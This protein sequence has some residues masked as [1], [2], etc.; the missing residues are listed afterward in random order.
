MPLTMGGYAQYNVAN[1]AGAALAANAL[2]ISAT[3]I[4]AVFGRFGAEVDD[5][6]GRMMR[7][8][9]GGVRILLDYAHNPDGLRGFL[10]VAER[11]RGASGRFG[12]L[13]GHAGNRQ[14]ADIE[15]LA[16]VAA[17]S[18]PDLVVVK[19]IP[20]HLRGRAPGEIPRIIHDALLSAGVPGSAVVMRD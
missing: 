15:A 6:P 13:L 9:I 14:D 4:A 12:M 11:L 2:G 20:T 8:D 16:R 10:A 17:Q 18:R 3:T 5:N 1:L 19:E 7:Y